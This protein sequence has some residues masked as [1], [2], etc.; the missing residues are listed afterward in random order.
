MGKE[1]SRSIQSV[2]SPGNSLKQHPYLH[3]FSPTAYGNWSSNVSAESLYAGDKEDM[4]HFF[5]MLKRIPNST[6]K[7]NDSH[8]SSFRG[9]GMDAE[10]EKSAFESQLNH[11][12]I[13]G[14]ILN[15]FDS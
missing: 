2:S 6:T 5:L 15:L 12:L 10:S 7:Y 14:Q 11:I 13:L 4:G 9:K 1:I 3:L 8:L